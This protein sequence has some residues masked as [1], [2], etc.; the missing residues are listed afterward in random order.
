MPTA[1][2]D[3]GAR[4]HDITGTTRQRCAQRGDDTLR[5]LGGDDTLI[6]GSGADTM[7]RGTGD[8]TY[9][10]D[11][12]HDVVTELLGEGTDTVVSSLLVTTLDDNVE[13]LTLDYVSTLWPG[14]YRHRQRLT[15][16]GGS[17]N[18][19]L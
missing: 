6:G 15:L 3:Y 2:R 8:D 14:P 4:L 7:L 13:N 16:I 1:R 10:V 18:D 5:R 19:V 9:H 11:S 17:G 12:K